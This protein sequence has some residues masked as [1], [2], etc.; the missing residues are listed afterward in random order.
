L[1]EGAVLVAD[2][3]TAGRGQQGTFW[4][5]EAGKNITCSFLLYP[6]FLSL[7]RHFLL[8]E[9]VALGVKEAIDGLAPQHQPFSIKWP[10]DIY[11]GNRKI[12]GILIENDLMQQQIT[13]SIVGVGLNVN[14]ERFSSSAPNP[15]SLKQLTGRSIPL[16]IVLD[17]MLHHIMQW[18]Q[19]LKDGQF[20]SISTAYHKALFRKTGFYSYADRQGLFN[21]RIESVSDD[22]FLHLASDSG[23]RRQYA[24][25]EVAFVV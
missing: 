4:E 10:N 14:Q 18:Y 7:S 9:V 11:C 2:E 1:E 15:V 16:N 13:R 5:A 17:K 21:A 3:Q 12:A 24:F 19:Q 25:K 6:A 22:G 8:S 20:E 23:D